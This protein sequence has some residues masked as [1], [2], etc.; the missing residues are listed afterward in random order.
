VLDGVGAVDA[1]RAQQ[2]IGEWKRRGVDGL[3]TA[4]VARL[5]RRAAN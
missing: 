4:T 1:A 5:L 2:V 3:T